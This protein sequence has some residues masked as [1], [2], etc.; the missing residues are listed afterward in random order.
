MKAAEARKTA[1]IVNTDLIASQYAEIMKLIESEANKGK[2]SCYF[3]NSLIPDVE[4]KLRED[5]YHINTHFDQRDGTTII[6][7]W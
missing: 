3:Y 1:Y 2:Y 7:E 5:G 4:N 6:I